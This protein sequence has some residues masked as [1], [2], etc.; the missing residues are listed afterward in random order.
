MIKPE[1]LI[2]GDA[3]RGEMYKYCVCKHMSIYTNMLIHKFEGVFSV[4]S[5]VSM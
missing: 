5:S 3:G 4:L 1:D 2:H